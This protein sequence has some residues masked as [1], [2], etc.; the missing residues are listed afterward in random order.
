VTRASI[1]EYAS[2]QRERYRT[3]NRSQ[4]RQILDEA[5][6]VTHYHRKAVIRLLGRRDAPRRSRRRV[7]RPR[8]YGPAVAAAAK[9]LWE[10]AAQIRA[11]RLHPFVPE[12]LARLSAHGEIQLSPHVSTLL[13]QASAATLGRL[14][15]PARAELPPRGHTTT[16]PGSWLKQQ[17]PVRTFADW[18]DARPGFLEADLVSHCG[19]TTEGFYLC[20]LCSVDIA[21]CWVE[22]EAVWGK[23]QGRV[24][25]AVHRSRL[26][27]PVPLL[28]FDSDNGSEFINQSLF[29]Y[30][31]EEG[32]TFTRSRPC[33]KNDNAHVEQKNGAIVRR[34]VGYDRYAT[35]AAHA[36]LCRVY[37]LLRLHINFFQPVQKLLAKSRSGARLHRV[38]GQALTPYQ[39]L[40]ALDALSSDAQHELQALY[41]SLNPLQ[42]RRRIDRELSRLWTLATPFQHTQ[43]SASQ[44]TLR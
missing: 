22:L 24:R 28:G 6:A 3:A 20:T 44:I 25:A 19:D 33:K 13:R 2:A 11:Q 37:E 9:V 26:R 8:Q 34:F 38:Y 30:C 42:L 40:L 23:G 10:A 41:E 15:A 21:S 32:I 12:L 35:K 36:Q 31:R 43:T 14:L 29:T 16:R 27:L 1:R 4:K 18:N 5:V 7:G 17:I 39:R